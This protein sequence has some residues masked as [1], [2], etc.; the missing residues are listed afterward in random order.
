MRVFLFVQCCA[1]PPSSQ[2]YT[3]NLTITWYGHQK[4]PQ[5]EA[6]YRGGSAWEHRNKTNL[7]DSMAIA[8]ILVASIN[9]AKLLQMQQQHL[10]RPESNQQL[11]KAHP[12]CDPR[13]GN[14]AYLYICTHAPI[15]ARSDVRIGPTYIKYVVAS[16]VGRFGAMIEYF[17]GAP[18]VNFRI[19]AVLYGQWRKRSTYR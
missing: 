3:S 16:H 18:L 10:S 7:G 2:P 14:L 1:P 4:A 17:L 11:Q 19:L 6:R 12:A 5:A 13:Q 8:N 15:M 9:P